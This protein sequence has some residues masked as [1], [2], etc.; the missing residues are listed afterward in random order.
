MPTNSS[1]KFSDRRLQ[2]RPWRLGLMFA[3]LIVASPTTAASIASPI[4][5][6]TN[7]STTPPTVNSAEFPTVRGDQRYRIMIRSFREIRLICP[8]FSLSAYSAPELQHV[9]RS[10]AALRRTRI[11]FGI[12]CTTERAD[13]QAQEFEIVARRVLPDTQGTRMIAAVID[14]VRNAVTASRRLY[15]SRCP[16][17]QPFRFYATLGN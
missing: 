11:A 5:A 3:Q 14:S 2:H 13:R 15:F 1:G 17:W 10:A 4:P 6:T 7:A 16:R 12:Q 8:A 9:R